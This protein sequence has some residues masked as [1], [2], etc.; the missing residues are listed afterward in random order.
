[1]AA[2]RQSWRARIRLRHLWCTMPER[3]SRLC[4]IDALRGLAIILMVPANLAEPHAVWY[5]ILRSFAAP[6]FIMLSAGMVV[7][8]AER[9][10]LS[11][12]LARIIHVGRNKVARSAL[13]SS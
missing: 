10:T 13:P 9:H 8:T 1:M 2:G 11:Y 7:L 4:W 5:R 12:Y 3:Q 6:I